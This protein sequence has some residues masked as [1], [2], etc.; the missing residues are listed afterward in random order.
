MQKGNIQLLVIVIVAAVVG[1]FVYTNY[2]NKQTNT[3]SRGTTAC[4]EETRICPDGSN[5]SRVPPSCEFA[6][7][8]AS[9]ADDTADWKTYTNKVSGYSLKYPADEFVQLVCPGEEKDYFY[10]IKRSNQ[11][12]DIVNMPTCARG[13]RYSVEITAKLPS[14]DSL[15]SNEYVDVVKDTIV[16]DDMNGEKYTFTK[17][18]TPSPYPDWYTILVFN[19]ENLEIYFDDKSMEDIFDR[20]LSTFRFE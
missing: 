8:P 2:S 3:S 4:T 12:E 20:I 16:V 10:L 18:N 7:C 15:K 17:T 11:K 1:Y 14:S 19:N 6:A 5:V 9:S 13:G